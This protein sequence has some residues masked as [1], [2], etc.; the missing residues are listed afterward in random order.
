MKNS[1]VIILFLV[2]AFVLAAC[3]VNGGESGQ[4][5]DLVIEFYVVTYEDCPWDGPGQVSVRVK[6]SGSGDA[7]EFATEING[8]DSAV[9]SELAAGSEKDATITFT[10][11]PVGGVNAR[12]D[13]NQ[14]VTESNEDN[15]GYEIMF[16]PPPPCAT[17]TP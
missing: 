9:I 12:A 11:G 15:N 13:I 16:T 17:P 6:N 2:F 8:D 1:R 7:G 3:A 14:Q 4:Q 5:P 10:S